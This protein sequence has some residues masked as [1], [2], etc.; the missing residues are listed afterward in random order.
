M[1][2]ANESDCSPSWQ[3]AAHSRQSLEGGPAFRAQSAR[4]LAVSGT[5]DTAALQHAG[6][7]ARELALG[8][9]PGATAAWTLLHQVPL[10][11]P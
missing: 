6:L 4:W 9:A 1:E 10:I 5:M 3:V 2:F 11:T 7:L 8:G